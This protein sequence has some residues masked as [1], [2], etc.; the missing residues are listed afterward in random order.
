MFMKQ[1]MCITDLHILKENIK[2]LQESFLFAE[3][4]SPDVSGRKK[5][6]DSE[7]EMK[8]EI[9][10][11]R[12][13][14]PI[15]I[16]GINSEKTKKYWLEYLEES[17]DILGVWLCAYLFKTTVEKYVK[18]KMEAYYEQQAKDRKIKPRENGH[19]TRGRPPLSRKSSEKLE[20]P[21]KKVK[22]A[23]S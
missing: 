11:G 14:I 13:K 17:I 22:N 19:T 18:K 23:I 3:Y 21:E 6:E 7:E 2:S 20:K 4:A 16:W 1:F 10:E 15:R 12:K 9:R 8:E 5:V